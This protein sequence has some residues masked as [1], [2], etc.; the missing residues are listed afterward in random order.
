MSGIPYEHVCTV[1]LFISQN[2]VEFVD[3]MFNLPA[4]QLV[5]LDT[6]YGIEMMTCRRS[7]MMGLFEMS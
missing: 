1:I 3:D 2:V 6:F 7:M 5:Y 4:Q